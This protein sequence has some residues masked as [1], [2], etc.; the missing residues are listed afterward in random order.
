MPTGEQW[1]LYC[2][3]QWGQE[4]LIEWA[5]YCVAITFKMTEGVEQWICIKFCFKLEHSSAKTIWMIPKAA[6]MGNWWLAASSQQCA[7]SCIT[8]RASVFWQN[9]KSPRWLSLP[10]A[11]ICNFWLFPKLK[12]PLKGK[13]FQAI[14]EI[15]ENTVGQLMAIGRTLWGPKVPT[16][17][18]TEASL[19]YVQCFLYLA[20]SSINVSNFHYK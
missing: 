8:S 16:L 17:K 14:S 3:S 15:Q 9:I 1:W 5:L 19:S 13:K 7:H 18:G 4:P 2:T 20:S 10:T 11:Q 6:A 12:S